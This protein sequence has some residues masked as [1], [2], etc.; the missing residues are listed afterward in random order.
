MKK[1][2]LKISV[3]TFLLIFNSVFIFKN[4]NAQWVQ[5]SQLPGYLYTTA[6]LYF[7]NSDIYCGSNQDGLYRS[8]NLGNSWSF[9]N[10]SNQKVSCLATSGSTLYSGVYGQGIFFTTD[11]SIT[12]LAINNGLL[13]LNVQTIYVNGTDLYAGTFDGGAFRSSNNGTSWIPINTGLTSLNVTSFTANGTSLFVGTETGVFIST[14]NGASWTVMN[15]GLT[16]IYIS[17]LIFKGNV[18]FAGTHFVGPFPGIVGKVF[19]STN[20]GLNWV[21]QTLN[22]DVTDVTG[23][24]ICG[25]KVFV[26][27]GFNVFYTTNNGDNWVMINS[28][29]GMFMTINGPSICLGNPSFGLYVS[30]DSGNI[31]ATKYVNLQSVISL[32]ENKANYYITTDFGEVCRTTNNGLSWT[33]VNNGIRTL[34]SKYLAANGNNLFAS[35]DVNGIYIS[36]NDGLSW[37]AVNLGLPNTDIT[38]LDSVGINIYAG[39]SD[40]V[41][42]TTNNGNLWLQRG[43][44]TAGRINCIQGNNLKIFAATDNGIYL[45]TNN[46][47]NWASSNTG[48]TTSQVRTLYI[49]GNEII[50]G[51]A[52]GGICISTDDGASWIPKNNGLTN[53]DIYTLAAKDST[54]IAGTAARIY[55]STNNGESWA[56]WNQG[57]NNVDFIVTGL[58][59]SG[60]Y[61]MVGSYTGFWQGVWRRSFTQT[62]INYISAETPQNFYLSQNYPNPFNPVTKISFEIP[63]DAKVKLVVYD[64]LGREVSTLIND[65]TRQAGKYTMEFNGQAFAS[66]VYFYRIEAHGTGQPIVQVRKMVLVK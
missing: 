28:V 52:G 40:G 36:T 33:A 39:T 56:K 35:T 5:T 17:S 25:S 59:L 6:S 7:F 12:W 23:L 37:T 19:R 29:H 49:N 27:T 42:L 46:G 18:M 3:I 16:N 55:L 34:H 4:S 66:G 26:G 8:T 50:A 1:S 65:E 61:L 54:L 57:F 9:I 62:N 47:I 10:F 13:N 14:N 60:N 2:F 58:D 22:S 64:M 30:T 45:S 32:I 48:L 53:Q 63:N 41:Y 51:T 11:N 43:L 31:W 15:T 44:Q 38:C 24:G 21:E 20:F